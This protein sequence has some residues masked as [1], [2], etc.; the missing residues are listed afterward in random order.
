MAR[1][2]SLLMPL[3]VSGLLHGVLVV[4]L[5]WYAQ[6]PDYLSGMSQPIMIQL[7]TAVPQPAVEAK[8]AL[9]QLTPPV[10]EEPVNREIVKPLPAPPAL[11]AIKVKPASS[12][13]RR[14]LSPHP[15]TPSSTSGEGGHEAAPSQTDVTIYGAVATL[16]AAP[17]SSTNLPDRPAAYQLN[18]KPD[19]PLMARRMAMEG[20]VL[21]LVAVTAA[22]QPETVTLQR[23]SGYAVLDRSAQ[24]AVATWQFVPALRAGHPVAATIEVP[25]VF[26]LTNQAG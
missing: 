6:P 26:R 1:P 14:R 4:L 13:P 12:V 24:E 23:S 8:P 17:P 9:P 2:A 19:Y 10:T 18:P 11:A 3:L 22:G 25:V 20:T 7:V 15:P 21:L 5:A 16:A